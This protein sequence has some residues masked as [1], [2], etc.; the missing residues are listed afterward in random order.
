LRKNHAVSLSPPAVHVSWKRHPNTLLY[1]PPYE[2]T[3][4]A[5]IG[6]L[7]TLSQDVIW[8]NHEVHQT[9]LFQD[10]LGLLVPQGHGVVAQ[11]IE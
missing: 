1:T 7:S 8:M 2:R 9:M 5:L 6:A 11:N 3:Q 4:Q 10:K